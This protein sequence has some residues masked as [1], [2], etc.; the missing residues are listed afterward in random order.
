MT[1]FV[2]MNKS[3]GKISSEKKRGAFF[4]N[5]GLHTRDIL[6]VTEITKVSPHVT[7]LKDLKERNRDCKPNGHEASDGAFRNDSASEETPRQVLFEQGGLAVIVV[8]VVVVVVV[9]DV[10]VEKVIRFDTY[11]GRI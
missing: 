3:P 9:V 8:V 4:K 1:F 7:P 5:G 2:R 10:V 11:I 6:A